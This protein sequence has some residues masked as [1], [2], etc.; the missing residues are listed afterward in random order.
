MFNKIS[1]SHAN[2][3]IKKRAKKVFPDPPPLSFP[4]PTVEFLRKYPN[5]PPLGSGAGALGDNDAIKYRVVCCKRM[6]VKIS[7][8]LPVVPR[9]HKVYL[10]NIYYRVMH[11]VHGPCPQKTR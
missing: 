11:C 4:F 6:W 9:V 10:D 8:V 3:P 2:P 7:V 1:P 5:P